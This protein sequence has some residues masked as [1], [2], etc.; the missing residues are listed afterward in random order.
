MIGKNTT[1][2]RNCFFCAFFEVMKTSF[3]FDVQ[4]KIGK[5]VSNKMIS[6]SILAETR[7]NGLATN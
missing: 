7:E 5:R 6:E 4:G 3:T 2:I 1:T